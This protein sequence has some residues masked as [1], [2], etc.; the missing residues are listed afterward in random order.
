M[1]KRK[2]YNKF[3]IINKLIQNQNKITRNRYKINRKNLKR[4]QSK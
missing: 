1:N 2:I 3:K 4:V